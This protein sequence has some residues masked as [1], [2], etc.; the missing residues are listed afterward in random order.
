MVEDFDAPFPPYARSLSEDLFLEV[1]VVFTWR[2]RP[3]YG[4]C[5]GPTWCHPPFYPLPRMN[6]TCLTM[7]GF[8]PNGE[9]RRR[10]ASQSIR[11]LS[12]ITLS[13]AG[14]RSDSMRQIGLDWAQSPHSREARAME[15]RSCSRFRP[16]SGS[17][18]GRPPPRRCR[19]GRAPGSHEG[20]YPGQPHPQPRNRRGRGPAPRPGATLRRLRRRHPRPHAARPGRRRRQRG[21]RR[22]APTS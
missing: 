20:V 4:I 8:V 3:S 1:A 16:W 6:S 10:V 12:A 15:I 11:R 5:G 22:R 2:S 7:R 19:R 21:P 9:E 18:P 13:I 14:A 17:S